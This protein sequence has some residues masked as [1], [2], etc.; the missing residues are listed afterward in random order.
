MHI[1]INEQLANE[2]L[3][4]TKWMTTTVRGGGVKFFSSVALGPSVA[5]PPF[6]A[7]AATPTQ[8]SLG[9]ARPTIQVVRAC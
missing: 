9:G 3:M 8:I 5:W 6:T 7:E 1:L 2:S 4:Y